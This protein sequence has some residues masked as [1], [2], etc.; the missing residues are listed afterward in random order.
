[1]IKHTG[2]WC[3]TIRKRALKSKLVSWLKCDV[4]FSE[5]SIQHIFNGCKLA[6]E[7]FS[8]FI[9]WQDWVNCVLL[10]QSS[11]PYITY[12]FPLQLCCIQLCHSHAQLYE[13]LSQ[14]RSTVRDKC[15]FLLSQGAEHLITVWNISTLLA[16]GPGL[17]TSSYEGQRQMKAKRRMSYTI[18][19]PNNLIIRVKGI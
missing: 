5:L 11:A 17:S 10:S 19:L 13:L 18:S 16:T 15:L 2:L 12:P 8:F 6:S 7:V 9:L 3:R 14:G 1:M 4:F